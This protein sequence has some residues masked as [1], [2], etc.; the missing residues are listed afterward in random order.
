MES[1]DNKEQPTTNNDIEILL[2]HSNEEK[3]YHL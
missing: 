2:L 3:L 1:N